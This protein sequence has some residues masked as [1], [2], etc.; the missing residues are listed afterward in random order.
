[1]QA[2]RLVHMSSAILASVVL[3]GGSAGAQELDGDGITSL[4][5]SKAVYL[6]TP[7]GVE[8]P[9]RYGADGQVVGDV[10]GISLASMFAPKETGR[11]WVDGSKLCQQWPSWYDGKTLCFTV[12]KTGDASISWVRDDGLNGTAR[13]AD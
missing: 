13:I 6:S 10:S 2:K 12:T 7:Y 11:W 9:L 3:S 8:L 5:A 4:I 1:M